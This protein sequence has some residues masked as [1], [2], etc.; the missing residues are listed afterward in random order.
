[1]Q[2][3][4]FE[5]VERNLLEVLEEQAGGLDLEQVGFVAWPS[6]WPWGSQ[7][8]APCGMHGQ[9]CFVAWPW[10]MANTQVKMAMRHMHGK[11]SRAARPWGTVWGLGLEHV[12]GL[13]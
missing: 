6:A 8:G 5:Y 9:L 2:Y 1:M 13:C 12:H 10:V 11:L 4:V 7:P 3:L